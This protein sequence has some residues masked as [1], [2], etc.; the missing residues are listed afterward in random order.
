MR[1]WLTICL[2]IA[3]ACSYAQQD[4]IHVYF[5]AKSNELNSAAFQTID[6]NIYYDILVK[7]TPAGIIGYADY[8][9]NSK[10]NTELAQARAQ[11]V[12]AYLLSMGMNETDI[13]AI[14]GVLP[15]DKKSKISIPENRRVDIIVGGFKIPFDKTL[16]IKQSPNPSVTTISEKGEIIRLEKLEFEPGTANIKSDTDPALEQL[17]QSMKENEQITIQIE[18]HVCCINLYTLP[19]NPTKKDLAF[20]Q[21]VEEEAILLSL[22]RAQKVREY[23]AKNGISKNRMKAKGLGYSVPVYETDGKTINQKRNRRVEIRILEK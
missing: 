2:V 8:P 9:G 22:K 12:V 20:Q 13:Q 6:S 23:L 16:P 10:A 15:G 17:L 11:T 14:D 5:D 1:Y 19:A 18:G 3:G 21:V 7:G 4:T